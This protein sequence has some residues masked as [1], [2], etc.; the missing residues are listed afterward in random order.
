[1]F[2]RDT[3]TNLYYWITEDKVLF[4]SGYT[5]LLLLVNEYLTSTK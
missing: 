2:Y 5:E 3:N 4:A 1:M